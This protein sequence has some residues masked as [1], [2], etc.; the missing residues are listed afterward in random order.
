M[1]RRVFGPTGMQGRG[2]L[3]PRAALVAVVLLMVS[4]GGTDAALADTAAP[5]V[6]V[7]S[8]TTTTF[9]DRP[10]HVDVTFS[11]P[12]DGFALADVTV[13]NGS[14]VLEVAHR[15]RADGRNVYV[16]M[17]VP[18]N[19]GI[20]DIRVTVPAG[21]ATDAAGNAN[22]ASTPLVIAR[23][24]Y[25]LPAQAPATFIFGEDDA[26][27]LPLKLVCPNFWPAQPAD[28]VTVAVQVDGATIPSEWVMYEPIGNGIAVTQNGRSVKSWGD[29]TSYVVL[30]GAPTQMKLGGT[31]IYGSTEFGFNA[32]FAA[33][34]TG[35]V[36]VQAL[37]GAALDYVGR[38]SGLSNVLEVAAGW[39]VNVKARDAEV[40]EGADAAVEFE[41][42][43]NGR[44][45]CRTVTVNFATL[46]G[47]ATAGQ[48][49]ESASG[50]LTFL[51]GE[52]S[53]TVR[54][55]VLDDTAAESAETFRLVLSNAKW[56]HKISLGPGS[57]TSKT[58]A[59]GEPTISTILDTD[60]LTARFEN[61]PESHDGSTAFTFELHFSEDIPGLSYETVADGLFEVTGGNVTKASRTT[62]GS[63]QGWLVTVAPSGSGSKD[64]AISLPIRACGETA[65]ICTADNRALAGAISATVPRVFV[66]ASQ[67]SGEE[68]R[69]VGGATA[70]E[71]R[72]E[73]LLDGQ[74]GTVCDDY[75]GKANADVACRALGYEE[76]SVADAT[77]FM[78]AYFGAGA[79]SMPIWLDNVQCAGTET[80]LLDCPRRY[81]PAVGTHNCRHRED[82][83]VRCAGERSGSAAVDTPAVPLTAEFRSVPAEHDGSSAFTLELAFS[84]EPNDLSY[85]TVRDTLFAVSGGRIE[86][87]RR[88]TPGSDLGF[89]V[90]VK[91]SGF[92]TVTLSLATLPACGQT[93]SVCTGNSRALEGTVGA[94]VP[95]P[96]TLSVADAK[97]DEAQGATLDFVVTLS[98][99]RTASTTVDYATSDGTAT[100]GA[101]Y[102]AA[103]GTLTF[104]ASETEKTVSVAVLDDALDEGSETLTLTLSNPAPSSVRLS[105]A[106]AT[107]TIHNTDMMPR[108]WIARFGRTVGG[109]VLDA[110]EARL[111]TG[112]GSYAR[113][114]GHRLGGTA[115]VREMMPELL[116]DHDLWEGIP[117]TGAAGRDTTLR[118]LLLGSAFHLAA[119]HGEDASG[120]SLT[121]WGRVASSRFDGREDRLSLNGRVTTATLGVD[122][123]WRRW[124][125]GVALAYSEGDGSF[126]QVGAPGGDV[127]STLTSIHPYAAYAL[128]DRIRLWSMIGYGSG[129]LQLE[130]PHE[131]T[132]DLEM[133]MGAL[134]VSGT[135]LAPSQPDGGLALAL[136]SDVLWMGMDS[137]AT[138]DLVATEADVSRLR[139]ML[140]GSRPFILRSGGALTPSI[141]VGLRHDGGDA[142]TGSG[143]EVGGRIVYTSSWGLS[144]ETAVRGLLTHEAADYDEW[145]VSGA[146]RLDPGHKGRGLS[147][148]IVPAWGSVASGVSRLWSQPGAAGLTPNNP[149]ASPD[150]GRLDA[151]LGY[152]LPALNGRGLM[153]PYAR[154][155]LA[156]GD[157]QAWHL[158]T[159]LSLSESLNL[160]LEARSRDR[161]GDPTA[162]ELSL[163]VAM[164]W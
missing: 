4:L 31:V 18:N 78:R 109:H 77:Q 108:A 159:R 40:E 61:V 104:A 117:K 44:D 6:T 154:V 23:G 99:A 129:S 53:K 105:D 120:P 134:G 93:G 125:T 43:L 76:G 74:W 26:T 92:G 135:L 116:P 111:E 32:N 75:W 153:T 15:T 25:F 83:G 103:S 142:E 60:P 161:K 28:G 7:T 132:T 114:A 63:N 147:A 58:I 27:G 62:Q 155:A 144:L 163:L 96:V 24:A 42:T 49:Y 10:F 141:E 45:D 100:A 13:E 59:M 137:A 88:V 37:R 20:G 8:D 95:G 160:S 146:L 35:T 86:S 123:A 119:N 106:E 139:L 1:M 113:L 110:L 97:V 67:T 50:T 71:G 91:P 30:A 122:G 157:S 54:V 162:H 156:E 52:M 2:W 148:A 82:V 79:Q 128:S 164:P 151:E 136:R 33:G 87:A 124:L 65:G 5:S 3:R 85:K 16:I 11:E 126:T 68:L 90:T 112:S 66:T 121:A 140:E 64:I 81:S 17:I 98:R 72:L 69:L 94:T 70:N 130:A 101:D 149:V 14:A 47:T 89:Y 145:T 73:M 84:E 41:V 19:G 127:D 138:A 143:L 51:P 115:Q 39:R 9:Q 38:P 34:T 56:S 80:S 36:Q 152:G 48:D 102:T 57:L 12:V 21:V 55:V 46:D 131:L 158:G 150:S 22:S 133:T 107:G 118:Q 29:V